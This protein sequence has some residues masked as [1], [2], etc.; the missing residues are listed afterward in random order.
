M[1]AM[2]ST[3]TIILGIIVIVLIAV[4]VL[5]KPNKKGCKNQV[6]TP[7]PDEKLQAEKIDFSTAYQKRWLFSYNEKDAFVKIKGIADKKG[8]TLLSKVRL[9]DLVE[10]QK[11]NPKY[12]TLFYKIQAKHVDF[13]ICDEKLVA[14]YIIELDDSSH[15]QKDRIARDEF[16][17]LVLK[18]TGYKILHIRAI[19]PAAIEKFLTEN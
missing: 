4:L 11:G 16:V 2:P 8:F 15:D 5:K 12:K 3:T 18:N 13:V 1:K 9:L 6:D 14:R 17:D 19:D 10:P 7:E